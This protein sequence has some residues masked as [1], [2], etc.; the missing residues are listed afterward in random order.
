MGQSLIRLLLGLLAWALGSW[1]VHAQDVRTFIPP[2][3]KVYAPVLVEKQRQVWPQ[4]PEPWTLGGLA[5]QES[6][7]GLKSSRCWNPRTELKTSREY[8][9]GLPQITVTSRFNKFNELVE[10]HESLRDWKWEDRYDPGFQL[11]AMAEMTRSLWRRLPPAAT[12]TD[13]WG[14]VLSSYN[15]GISG[16]LQDKRLCANTSGCDPTRWLGHVENTS[17]KSRVPQPAYGGRSWFQ[18]NREHARNVLTLRRDK[19][20]VFWSK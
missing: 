18:I 4:A 17:M 14:F 12:A 6:C 3:A 1:S 8:G 19:Y 10:A 7:P 20:K 11:T 16:A 2:G 9:F 15:G 13:H 5:E